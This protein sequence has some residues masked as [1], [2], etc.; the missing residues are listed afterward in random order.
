MAVSDCPGITRMFAK[1]SHTHID[2]PMNGQTKN[3]TDNPEGSTRSNSV[4]ISSKNREAGAVA[5]QWW[6]VALH[7]RLDAHQF[8]R[9]SIW[10]N[11]IRR[12][13]RA[14]LITAKSSSF[15]IKLYFVSYIKNYYF[16]DVFSNIIGLTYQGN[17]G[18]VM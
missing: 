3:S 10:E 8:M 13:V 9:K 18:F 2:G 5:N 12:C 17:F 11:L 7:R 1:P 4:D 14:F 15:F 16:H 6:G